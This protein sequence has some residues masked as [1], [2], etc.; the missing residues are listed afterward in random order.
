MQ[1]YTMRSEVHP[2]KF[3][4]SVINELI[5]PWKNVSQKYIWKIRLPYPIVNVGYKKKK[6]KK[7]EAGNIHYFSI[8]LKTSCFV[9]C[10]DLHDGNFDASFNDVILTNS[11]ISKKYAS[12]PILFIVTPTS[13]LSSIYPYLIGSDVINVLFNKYYYVSSAIVANLHIRKVR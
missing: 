13:R 8:F 2:L 4:P 5:V 3:Y 10:F 6:R 1:T 12:F 11:Y 7:K 9:L